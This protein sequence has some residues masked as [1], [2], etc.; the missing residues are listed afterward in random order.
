MRL[1]GNLIVRWI[2]DTESAKKKRVTLTKEKGGKPQPD[3][4]YEGIKTEK[5]E[6]K[7]RGHLDQAG[8]ARH[9]SDAQRSHGTRLGQ[10]DSWSEETAF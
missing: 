8:R 3:L 1:R 9:V 10:S 7:A 5:A 6:E 4:V 2:Y